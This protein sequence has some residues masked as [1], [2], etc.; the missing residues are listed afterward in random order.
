MP[1]RRAP[2]RWTR[3]RVVA[4]VAWLP[5]CAVLGLFHWACLLLDEVLFP[6]YRRVRVEGPVFIVGCPR[7][8]TTFLHRVLAKDTD[9]FTCYTFGEMVF[10]PSILQRKVLGAL[11]RIDAAF[12][13]PVEA[14]MRRFEKPFFDPYAHMH[15]VSV[16]APEE[17]FV[18]NGY[19]LA[20][21]LL[22]TVFPYPDLFGD[23]W[24]FDREVDPRRQ[25]RVTRFYRRCLQ[26]HLYCHGTAKIHL[27]KNPFFTSM[28][29][30]LLREFPDARF[31]FNVRD[32]RE[33]VPSFLS[34]WE[35]LY[36]G[37]GNAPDHPLARD[38]ILAWL[39]ETYTYGDDCTA[40]LPADRG[41][42]VPYHALV[43]DPAATVDR[44]YGAFGF[45]PSAAFRAVLAQ[46]TARAKG[47]TSAHSYD[48]AAYGLSTADIERQFAGVLARFAFPAPA[49]NAGR[50]PEADA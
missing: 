37:I 18:M 36:A 11:A 6:G 9:R 40:A 46:E 27:S 45:T 21:Q 50:P 4:M 15:R 32:P 23:L 8:G 48:P 12:G 20:N 31:I 1:G 3:P 16:F 34:V 30:S 42:R 39:L 25:A 24:R 47:Y 29:Q 33:N 2:L 49:A 43:A 41:I 28:I 38:F 22:L 35:A 26:R 7:G 10:T 19:V 13:G 5:L 14:W 17:D 44:I